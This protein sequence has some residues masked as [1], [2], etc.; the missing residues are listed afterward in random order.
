MHHPCVEAVT[1]V[2]FDLPSLSEPPTKVIVSSG[3]LQVPTAVEEHVGS[4]W[5]EVLPVNGTEEEQEA[6]REKV[7]VCSTANVHKLGARLCTITCSECS[8]QVTLRRS[9]MFRTFLGGWG[10][11]SR[12]RPSGSDSASTSP[13]MIARRNAE[14][15]AKAAKKAAKKAAPAIDIV[16]EVGGR[17]WLSF[18]RCPPCFW[19]FVGSLAMQHVV[20]VHLMHPPCEGSDICC[21]H[22]A[23]RTCTTGGQQGGPQRTGGCA[24]HRQL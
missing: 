14:K 16:A 3:M 22:V 21:S 13:Q 15:A 18:G 1:G 17:V 11:H 19:C 23:P 6:L 4:K 7:G 20:P 9:V 8:I 10:L 12:F 5:E 24:P 2:E